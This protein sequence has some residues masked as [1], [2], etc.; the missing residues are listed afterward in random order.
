[1]KTGPRCSEKQQFVEEFEPNSV[2]GIARWL[3]SLEMVGYSS[4]PVVRLNLA[5]QDQLQGFPRLF[6]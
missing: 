6:L 2:T 4:C 1:V 3:G 5:E